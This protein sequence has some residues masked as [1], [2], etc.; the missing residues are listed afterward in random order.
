ME[1]AVCRWGSEPF[2]DEGGRTLFFKEGAVCRRGMGD[3]ILQGR[4]EAVHRGGTLFINGGWGTLFF[5]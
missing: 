2:I 1:G 3:A 4:E 5:I